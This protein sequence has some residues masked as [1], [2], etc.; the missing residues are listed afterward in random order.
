MQMLQCFMES[1]SSLSLFSFWII[2]FSVLFIL[3]TLHY[4]ILW[5]INSFL[6]FH[7]AIYCIRHVSCFIYW[8]LYFC[9]VV[10]SVLRVSFMYSTLFSSLMS[11]FVIITLNSV[12]G[13]LFLFHLDLCPWPFSILSFGT[14]SSCLPILCK[15]L[16]LFL[17]VRKGSYI[18]S[19]GYGLWRRGP[20]VPCS[21]VSPLTLPLQGVSLMC[22]ACGLLLCLGHFILQASCL[23]RL[24]LP[25]VG[26]VWCLAWMCC[27]LASCALVCSWNETFHHCHWNQGP[28][29]LP[30]TLQVTGATHCISP[31]C[32]P[33]LLSKSG[34]SASRLYLNETHWPLD[35]QALSSTDCKNSRN[36][37]PLTFQAN[38]CGDLFSLL[39]HVC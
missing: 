20:V 27:I 14:D 39:L 21:V 19:W 37:A 31:G 36:S 15:S 25:L 11:I 23:Q 7:P 30:G 18:S 3:I 2:H 24:S 8:A 29:E 5:V 16:H 4:S 33:Y 34:P 17:C 32:L 9:Y 6:C 12:S 38:H 28:A 22:T 1:L 10:I 35:L 13:M 26:N